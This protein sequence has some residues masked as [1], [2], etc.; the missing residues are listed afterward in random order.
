MKALADKERNALL[1]PFFFFL[2]FPLFF[3]GF[4][5]VAWIDRKKRKEGKMRLSHF[6]FCLFVCLCD[7]EVDSVSASNLLLVLKLLPFC[8]LSGFLRNFISSH[9]SIIHFGWFE[10]KKK[11]LTAAL[12]QKAKRFSFLHRRR[13]FSSVPSYAASFSELSFFFLHRLC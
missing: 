3:L 10:K 7:K 11:K 6:F 13:T 12:R 8:L 2:Y 1:L 9:H 5:Y 4:S